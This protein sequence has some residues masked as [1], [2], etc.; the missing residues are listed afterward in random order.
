MYYK[1]KH[2]KLAKKFWLA[3]NH[4]IFIYIYRVLIG[5]VR[6]GFRL[7]RYRTDFSVISSVNLPKFQFRFRLKPIPISIYRKLN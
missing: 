6:F 5:S 4:I 3:N 7:N 2:K 1:L